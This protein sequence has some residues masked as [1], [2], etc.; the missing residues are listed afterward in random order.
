[1]LTHVPRH[2]SRY[3][4]PFLGGGSFFFAL[5]RAGIHVPAVLC[6]VNP[7]LVAAYRGV[8][9]D[10]RGV[11]AD[12]ADWQ[13]RHRAAPEVTY[14][15]AVD[16]LNNAEPSGGSYD[17]GVVIY[18][19]RVCFNGLWRVNRRGGFNVPLGAYEHARMELLPG[20][21]ETNLLAVSEALRDNVE[22][23]LAGFEATLPQV[24]VDDFAYLDPPYDD[25]ADGGFVGYTAGR[26]DWG[27]QERLA[28][29]A[30]GAS[31]RGASV[32]A[33]NADTERI[34]LL[35]LEE[36]GAR[37]FG[38]QAPRSISRDAG[39]RQ[40][41][42]EVLAV[43]GGCAARADEL[44]HPSE[45]SCTLVAPAAP[46]LTPEPREART[47][48]TP[49][50]DYVRRVKSN[51]QGGVDVV[52]GP[53]TVLY[54]PTESGKDAVVRSVELPLTSTVR[55]LV[56]RDTA[57]KAGDLMALAP[58]RRGELWAEIETASGATAS[59]RTTG[60]DG[61]AKDP[62]WSPL[63]GVDATMVLPMR[64]LKDAIKGS[65]ETAR[66][67]VLEVACG[68][69]TAKDVEKRIGSVLVPLFNRARG[70]ATAQ[71]LADLLRAGEFAKKKAKEAKD[72]VKAAEAV[73]AGIS[74]LP[75]L[76]SEEQVD[77]AKTA[78]QAAR[79]ALEA[80][81]VAD[82]APKA[83]SIAEAQ[84]KRAQADAELAHAR[85]AVAGWEAHVAKLN[86]EVHTAPVAP[87]MDPARA[88][89]LA[90][91]DALVRVLEHQLNLTRAH[92]AGC[93]LCDHA[94]DAGT[95]DLKA[96]QIR[97]AVDALK[98]AS[99]A[100]QQALAAHQQN[101]AAF[102]AEEATRAA[103]KRAAQASLDQWRGVV[104]RLE[105][106]LAAL[107]T[108]R[109][110]IVD[111]ASWPTPQGMEGL[112]LGGAGAPRVLSLD[113]ARMALATREAELRALDTAVGQWKLVDKARNDKVISEQEA[114]EWDQLVVAC[115]TAVRE[116]LDGALEGFCD[117]VQ[118]FLPKDHVFGLRLREGERDVFQFGLWR[119]PDP[120]GAQPSIPAESRQDPAATL[121][122]VLSGST[123][124]RVLVGLACAMIPDGAKLA[125]LIPDDRGRDPKELKAAMQ[126]ATKAPCQII[127]QSTVKPPAVKG[128]TIVEL[129]GQLR[130]GDAAP[131]QPEAGAGGDDEGDS[132][133]A[134]V[135]QGLG[136]GGDVDLQ[137]P[138]PPAW[139]LED[140]PGDGPPPIFLS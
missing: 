14:R 36:A 92:G 123:G 46:A 52:L 80:A 116:L 16:W 30:R 140:E 67:A 12:L 106:F 115:T 134:G 111:L 103:T 11:V 102:T 85:T 78:A 137:P 42:G 93:V 57:A 73:L 97:G 54:G 41:V 23:R 74:G 35:W 33:S 131:A 138:P 55:D 127:L 86:A 135:S 87:T 100:E 49:T 19:N 15:T 84:A 51:V 79:K 72:A 62:T 34:R 29:L 91:G 70:D 17:A 119:K 61:K 99:V 81:A 64:A 59:W 76:P 128:W 37:I 24:G 5:R 26:F 2:F 107:P 114:K 40:P 77:F 25:E 110:P 133:G 44:Q 126:A 101:L 22:I 3:Y 43:L 13:E 132:P 108:V 96:S 82:A 98:Q 124:V 39:G 109:A 4:E 94:L 105:G 120:T 121:H 65:P 47:M 50:H 28:K 69:I 1:M 60:G 9:Q 7:W 88:E 18:L 71:P 21:A 136:L 122:T 129:P 56:W 8:R 75:V 27:A 95:L 58:G 20:D 53:K 6:D 113:E 10:P 31:T 139:A 118:K 130:L 32:L 117:R 104:T 45:Q 48:S 90:R 68:K 89:R 63:P 125:V 112:D 38:I 83:P 66:K